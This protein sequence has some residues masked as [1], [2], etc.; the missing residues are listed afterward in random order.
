MIVSVIAAVARNGVIGNDDGLVW[1]LPGDMKHFKDTTIGHCVIMGRKNYESI[2]P[3]YR[4]LP[5]RPNIVVTRQLDYRAA[6]CEVVGSIEAGIQMARDK[7]ET[8]AFVI[9]GGEIYR[10][11]F[12]DDLAD[13]LY[14]TRIA[15]EFEGNV[16]FPEFD[17]TCWIITE[18]IDYEPDD[19]NKYG[20]SIVKYERNLS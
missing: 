20:Y 13:K 18:N 1:H 16:Y 2:P 17:K 8:E 6:G 4:P 7:M 19:R 5:N 9:G 14:I 11:V 12:A 15:A 10:Q 3:K